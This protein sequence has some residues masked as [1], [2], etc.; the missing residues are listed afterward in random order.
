MGVG[1]GVTKEMDRTGDPALQGENPA[2]EIGQNR[3]TV[4]E[5]APVVM[6]ATVAERLQCAQHCEEY[7]T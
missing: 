7:F 3:D 5:Q 1:L 6:T 2:G 4:K